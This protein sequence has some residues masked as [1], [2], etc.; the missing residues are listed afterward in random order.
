MEVYFKTIHDWL[1]EMKKTDETT[2]TVYLLAIRSLAN[3]MI[4]PESKIIVANERCVSSSNIRRLMVKHQ[5]V[6]ARSSSTFVAQSSRYNKGLKKLD[7]VGK[8]RDHD[9]TRNTIRETYRKKPS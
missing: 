1:W 3:H 4:G 9:G 2:M 8:Y 7:V 5:I 6:A